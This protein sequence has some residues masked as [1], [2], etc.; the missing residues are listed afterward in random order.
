MVIK[1]KMI[2]YR[3]R[4]LICLLCLGFMLMES[5]LSACWC[6]TRELKNCF[7][8]YMNNCALRCPSVGWRSFPI[9]YC[10]R[11]STGKSECYPDG[12]QK[13]CVA[14]WDCIEEEG[15]CKINSDSIV[16]FTEQDSILAGSSCSSI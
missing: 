15:E 4:M 7:D 14:M 8:I 5:N 9:Y 11:A 12:P 6:W 1:M 3:K 16:I 13:W 10:K 2:Q